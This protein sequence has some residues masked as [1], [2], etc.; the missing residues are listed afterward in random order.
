MLNITSLKLLKRTTKESWVPV[1]R[2][3]SQEAVLELA[4][5]IPLGLGTSVSATYYTVAGPVDLEVTAV[6]DGG[7]DIEIHYNDMENVPIG[8]VTLVIGSLEWRE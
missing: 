8:S 6:V 5:P 3:N 4:T 2:D 7:G 1:L